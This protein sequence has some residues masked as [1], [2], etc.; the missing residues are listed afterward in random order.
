MNYGAYY[1]RRQQEIIW[2]RTSQLMKKG[3]YHRHT[4]RGGT[5]GCMYS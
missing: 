3:F 2:F 5:P 1:R 4:R